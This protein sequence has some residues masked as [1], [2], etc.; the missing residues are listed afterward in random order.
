MN[1]LLDLWH[2]AVGRLPFAWAQ[3]EFMRH[4]LLA[5]LA[6]SPVLALLG[7]A[8]VNQRLAFFSD[9]LG[10]SALAGVGIGVLLGLADPGWAVIPAAVVAA[11]GITLVQE[12]ARVSPDTVIGVFLI[13]SM[14]LAIV[15]LA[16]GGGFGT[17]AGYIVG[18]LLAVGRGNAP[19]L[20][21]LCVAAAVA[22]LLLHNALLLVGLHPAL[23]ASRGVPVLAV[24]TAFAALV[25]T[26]VSANIGWIGVLVIN[27]LLV[28]P[29]AAARHVA[30]TSAG[31]A[32]GAMALGLACGVGGL[33]LSF[34][35]DTAT[36]ATIALLGVGAF[37]AAAA[38]RPGTAR[39]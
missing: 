15:I 31:H 36:G 34:E 7:T 4:A 5:V 27:A 25:A 12:R 14:A 8:V 38:L 9:A 26:V 19:W 10:H 11:V 21:G 29:A 6:A 16:R 18:D 32:L 28:L 3:F 23:A 24:R 33:L 20:V 30:R 17:Y 37:L 35:L 2:A 1:E 13:G 39:R 22:H